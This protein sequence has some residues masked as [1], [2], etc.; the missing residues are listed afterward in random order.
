MKELDI[1]VNY[2]TCDSKGNQSREH[3]TATTNKLEVVDIID[4]FAGVLTTLG[5]DNVAIKNGIAEYAYC[6]C[7]LD[8]LESEMNQDDDKPS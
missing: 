3:A 5:F 4:K 6:N 8:I 7:N 1:S 2:V